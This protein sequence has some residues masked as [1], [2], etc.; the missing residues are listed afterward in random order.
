VTAAQPI[1][2]ASRH[3][4][5]R[6]VAYCTAPFYDLK[7]IDEIFH[8]NAPPRAV[9]R[10]LPFVHVVNPKLSSDASSPSADVIHVFFFS[11]GSFVAWGTT[12]A[13]DN[14]WPIFDLIY[15]HLVDILLGFRA[16]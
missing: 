16:L 2:D 12:P 7:K 15:F 14:V 1:D 6:C 5:R 3:N 8:G 4:L 11:H 9:H 13:Q 10:A